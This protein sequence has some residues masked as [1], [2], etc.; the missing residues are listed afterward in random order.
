VPVGH[1]PRAAGRSHYGTLD[2]LA[3]GLVDLAGVFW[4]QRRRLLPEVE[5][6]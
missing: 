1:R 4:L 3:V 5:A 2:R 6:P